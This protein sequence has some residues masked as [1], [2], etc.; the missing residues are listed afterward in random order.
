MK[1]STDLESRLAAIFASEDRKTRKPRAKSTR[2]AS[3][4]VH[5]PKAPE[6][7]VTTPVTAAHLQVVA[8]AIIA[9]GGGFGRE[10]VFISEIAAA[11]GRTVADITP[12]L[13]TLNR[14]Q[15]ITLHRAD[16]VGAMDTDKVRASEVYS[17]PGFGATVHTME[18]I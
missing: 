8:R 9:A 3:K 17:I 12:Q 16:L 14:A 2:K 6:P 5:A 15:E 18:V 1:T 7:A 4:P 10:R 13:L 11:L